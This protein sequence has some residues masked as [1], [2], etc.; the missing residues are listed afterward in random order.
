[1]PECLLLNEGTKGMSAKT[2]CFL[3]SYA[4]TEAAASVPACSLRKS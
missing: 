2:I 1:L 4:L 3:S